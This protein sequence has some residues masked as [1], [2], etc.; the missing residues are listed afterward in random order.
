ML[1][2]GSGGGTGSE[3]P[4]T[5]AGEPD[6]AMPRH[7]LLSPAWRSEQGKAQPRQAKIASC[8]QLGPRHDSAPVPAGSF[9]H[10]L[11]FGIALDVAQRGAHLVEGGD[12]GVR[13]LEV[14]QEVVG[15]GGRRMRLMVVR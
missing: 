3:A 1:P 2:T 12:I 6:S 5:Y 10:E 4:G 11:P 14:G 7:R 8:E 15:A 9:A 13:A